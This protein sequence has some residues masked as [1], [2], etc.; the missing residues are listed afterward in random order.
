MVYSEDTTLSVSKQQGHD[1]SYSNLCEFPAKE[2]KVTSNKLLDYAVPL[3][4]TV[5]SKP[6]GLFS[7]DTLDCTVQ[8]KRVTKQQT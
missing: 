4:W 5:Q 8:R 2:Y 1:L 6:F 3:L 7:P